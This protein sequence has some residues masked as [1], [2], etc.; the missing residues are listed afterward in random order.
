VDPSQSPLP[1]SAT[2]AIGAR[3]IMAVYNE[4]AV[5]DALLN[6]HATSPASFT[7]N[8]YN[9]HWTLNNSQS[10][11]LYNNPVAVSRCA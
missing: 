6:Q 5:V 2:S 1:S 11:F 8:L 9:E 10:K 7:V 4:P 3:G